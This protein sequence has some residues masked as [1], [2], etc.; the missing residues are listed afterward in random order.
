ML[1]TF[2][3]LLIFMIRAYLY[4][5]LI[6]IILSYFPRL[7]GSRLYE[8]FRGLC[9]PLLEKFRFFSVGPISFAPLVVY[10]LLEMLIEIIIFI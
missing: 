4:S 7:R 3:L 2:K 10:M 5:M 9:E 8:F 6:Y 1:E